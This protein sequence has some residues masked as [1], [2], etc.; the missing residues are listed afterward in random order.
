MSQPVRILSRSELPPEGEAREAVCGA[1]T[2]CIAN[3]NGEVHAVDNVCP[4][5]GGPLG[6]GIV[7]NGNIVCPWHAWAFN[8]KSGAA[9][10]SPLARIRV[11][12]VHV[13]GDD[14]LVEID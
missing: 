9:E 3:A 1:R 5:R 4:H 10:H 7:E 13:E 6:Q 11:Y 2:L 14:V 12:P 8:L